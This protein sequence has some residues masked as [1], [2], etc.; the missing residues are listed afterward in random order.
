MSK[1]K[2]DKYI[3]FLF[4]AVDKLQADH[5]LTDYQVTIKEHT[6]EGKEFAARISV[7]TDYYRAMIEVWPEV[8]RDWEKKDYASVRDYMAHE[9]AHIR[10]DNLVQVLHRPYKTENEVTKEN[11]RLAEIVGRLMYKIT[12]GPTTS[13]RNKKYGRGTGPRKLQPPKRKSRRLR[14]Q[15]LGSSK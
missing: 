7:D 11:E 5:G 6:S 10:V 9:L 15:S 3:Q 2:K 12:Y 1:H 8:R 13:K 14:K 4:D